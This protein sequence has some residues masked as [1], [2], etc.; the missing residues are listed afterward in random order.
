YTI[1]QKT[2]AQNQIPESIEK[3]IEKVM[4]IIELL[5]NSSEVAPGILGFDREKTY[6]VLFQDNLE[7]RP[8]GGAIEGAAELGIKNGKITR[9]EEVDVASLDS[10]LKIHVEPSYA[11]R[12]FVPVEHLYLR[13]SNFD[14]DF[15][16]SAI[17]S[18]AIYK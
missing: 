7:L 4:P 18:A 10:V 15:V 9:F 14:P 6:L 16:S 17:S 3:R 11:L 8:G 13:D 12:R 2:K 1:I 5:S